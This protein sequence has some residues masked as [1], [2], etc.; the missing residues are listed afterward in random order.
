MAYTEQDKARVYVVL[1]ANEGIV[2]RTARETG[3]PEQTVRRW[4]DEWEKNGPP[5]TDEVESAVGDFVGDADELRFL[6]LQ[7]LRGKLELLIKTPKDVNVAQVTTLVGILTDKIDRARGLDIRRPENEP[8][9]L[10]AGQIRELLVGYTDAM[11]ELSSAREEE[12]I[13]AEIVEQPALPPG[14]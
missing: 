2:K 4:R 12:I 10:N 13:E 6:G 1:A 8:Q 9:S 5:S 3:V 7:A 11:R 14:S